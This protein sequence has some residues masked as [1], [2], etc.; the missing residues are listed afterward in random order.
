MYTPYQDVHA[1]E[2]IALAI[3]HC[4]LRARKPCQL[5]ILEHFRGHFLL[6]WLAKDSSPV[7]P[8]NILAPCPKSVKTWG[9]AASFSYQ[10]PPPPPRLR[11][12]WIFKL[13]GPLPNVGPLEMSFPGS[14]G[15]I[16]CIPAWQAGLQAVCGPAEVHLA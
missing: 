4:P 5:R 1:K 6:C 15:V 13:G 16:P 2:Y 7:R 3:S 14:G 9:D 11:L 12:T 10:A 8:A